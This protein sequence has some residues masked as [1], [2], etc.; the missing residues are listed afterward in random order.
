MIC[1]KCRMPQPQGDFAFCVR[2]SYP[3]QSSP[4]GFFTKTS[5]GFSKADAYAAAQRS[6]RPAPVQPSPYPTQQNQNI[7]TRYDANGNP[8]YFQTVYDGNGKPFYIQMIPQVMGY[9][10]S[11]KPVYTLV[12]VQNPQPVRSP[13][14]QPQQSNMQQS[15]QIQ[16]QQS[17]MPQS[18]QVQ[19]QQ[20]S[21]QQLR[22]PAPAPKQQPPCFSNH[23]PETSSKENAQFMAKDD[24]PPPPVPVM[25]RPG[26]KSDE[27]PVSIPDRPAVRTPANPPNHTSQNM[28]QPYDMH[29]YFARA[30]QQQYTV[31]EQLPPHDV[32]Q[33]ENAVT[34]RISENQTAPKQPPSPKPATPV[35]K[36]TAAVKKP[37]T[38]KK[39][40]PEHKKLKLFGKKTKESPKPKKTIVDP[41][42]IFGDSKRPHQV[43]MLGVTVNG[44]DADVQNKLKEMRYGGKKSV[45]SMQAAEQDV[46]VEA[47]LDDPQAGDAA[48]RV[49]EGEEV[50]QVY[51]SIESA[52]IAKVL[53]QLNQGIFP[54]KY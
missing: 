34:N 19:P 9:D 27:N 10:A 16:P 22:K 25:P 36:K 38:H 52:E 43:E 54:K 49:I 5:Q 13:Q 45:R 3:L 20:N 12:P 28:Q 44:T 23:A 26:E 14:V 24:A 40:E 33:N 50:K 15:P 8:V 18:R 17:S 46:T 6:Q 37:E 32:Q 39:P 1:P 41:D 2:C 29:S 48:R 42:A 51:E 35:Q 4:K 21:M 30:R 7:Q 47:M 31:A 53:E 11:G